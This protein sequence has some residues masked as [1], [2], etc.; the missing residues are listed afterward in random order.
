MGDYI[1]GSDL[2]ALAGQQSSSIVLLPLG[3]GGIFNHSSERPSVYAKRYLDQPF[4]QC[5][6]IQAPVQAGEE[7][8]INYGAGYWEAPWRSATATAAST[9]VNAPARLG[10]GRG[11][12]LDAGPDG[13]TTMYQ[14]AAAVV[15]AAAA[16]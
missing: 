15:A 12:W 2:V 16:V 9:H 6:G 7:L 11:E 13:R 8:L 4:L 5:W 10:R 3:Y 14:A 1:F